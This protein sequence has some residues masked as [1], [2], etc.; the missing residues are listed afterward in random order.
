M[1]IL[2]YKML[3]CYEN[4]FVFVF[5]YLSETEAKFKNT[6]ACLLGA[7]MVESTGREEN[8]RKVEGKVEKSRVGHPFFSKEPSVLFHSF[9]KNVPF[10]SVLL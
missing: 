8:G 9:I 1:E 3:I 10:F 7:K 2:K 6:L 5:E 4:V